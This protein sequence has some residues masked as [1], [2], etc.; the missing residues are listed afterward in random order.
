MIQKS[1]IEKLDRFK[2]GLSDSAE[3]QYIYS[4]FSE[5]EEIKDFKQYFL[6]EFDE[7]L[8]N[9]PDENHH[10]SYL[11]DRIHHTIHN[12]ENKKKHT[13]AGL[14]YR[15][16][17][18][19]AMLLVPILI[20][21]I[22]WVREQKQDQL[23]IAEAPATSSLYAPM[24]SRISFTLPD[25][26]RGWLNSGSSLKY[27]LPFTVNRQVAVSGEAWLDVAHDENHP[28][29]VTTGKSKVKVL[30]TKFNISAYPEENRV[31]VV[32]EEGK[33]EFSTP[34]LQADIKMKPNERLVFSD[35]S[36]NIRPTDVAKYSAWIEGK[37]VFRAEPMA[38]VAR[39]IER[40]YNAEVVLMDKDLERDLISGTFQ[41]DSLE[42]VFHYLS[43][44][45]P[46]RYKILNH[47]VN[48]D[49]ILQKPKVLL[50]REKI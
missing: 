28:F 30:G 35:G 5:N 25:G 15:W 38:E 2:K 14:I 27:S 18:V 48:A 26:T 10:L 23:I 43:M 19:A 16:Y 34:G 47:Q 32:L 37:L 29:E 6:T 4:L 49:G 7:Y 20:A 8:K 33:V 21:G 39:R 12:N 45:S 44:T 11:L 13:V 31:E 50:Y 3:K 46:I 40:W 17:S 36:V 9:N 1:D 24:G 42:D 22:V 41:D